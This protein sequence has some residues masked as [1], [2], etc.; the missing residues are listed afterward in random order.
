MTLAWWYDAWIVYRKG[1]GKNPWG[2]Y[3][4][5]IMAAVWIVVLSSGIKG[6]C[7]YMKLPLNWRGLL[8]RA[9]ICLIVV[10]IVLLLWYCKREEFRMVKEKCI[11]MIKRK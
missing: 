2:F 8:A 10:N 5:S 3:V 1:F 4:D 11:Q 9:F 7:N 6:F